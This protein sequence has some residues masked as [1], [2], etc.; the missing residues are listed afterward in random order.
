V[1][2]LKN[3]QADGVLGLS[4][5]GSDSLLQDLLGDRQIEQ[6][7]FSLSLVHRAFTFG[8]Y[9]SKKYAD[10]QSPMVWFKVDQ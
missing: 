6:K 7:V 2:G 3:M 8:G 4:P 1:K 10:K 5:V 9:D